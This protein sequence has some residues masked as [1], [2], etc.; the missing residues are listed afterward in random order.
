MP[1]FV[2]T[3]YS[4]VLSKVDGRAR[5]EQASAIGAAKLTPNAI[6]SACL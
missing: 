6:G 3:S 4:S 1:L 2:L 5:L